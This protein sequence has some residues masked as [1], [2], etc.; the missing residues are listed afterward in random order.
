MYVDGDD[1][2]SLGMEAD[3]GEFTRM[4]PSLHHQ[5]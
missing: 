3:L 1:R 4:L 5:C 2:K